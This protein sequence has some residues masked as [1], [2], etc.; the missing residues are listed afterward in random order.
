MERIVFYDGYCPMCN[1]WV[2]RLLAWDRARRLSFAPLEGETA[3]ALLTP[4]NPRYLAEDTV[5]YFEQGRMYVRSEAAL[6]IAG[7]LGFPF[8]LGLAGRLVPRAWRDSIYDAVASRRY[9]FGARYEA[10]PVPPAKWR[11]RFLP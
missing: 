8:S 1:G 3:R 9:K 4:L 10:C 5:I 11:G 6:Q 7:T 2:R